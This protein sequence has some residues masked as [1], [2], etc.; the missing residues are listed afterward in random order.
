M[1]ASRERTRVLAVTTSGHSSAILD[2]KDRH[3]PNMDKEE[4]HW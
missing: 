2:S 1:A 3:S 4:K